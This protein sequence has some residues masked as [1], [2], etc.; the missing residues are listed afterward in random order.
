VDVVFYNF[1]AP[2]VQWALG[3]LGHSGAEVK[4]YSGIYLGELLDKFVQHNDL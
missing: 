1:I 3:E 2:N 4:Y